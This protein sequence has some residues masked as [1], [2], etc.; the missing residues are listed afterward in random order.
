M[1]NLDANGTMYRHLNN[2]AHQRRS[3]SSSGTYSGSGHRIHER[4]RPA[5]EIRRGKEG[6][7][8]FVDLKAQ[9]RSIK[10]EI[11]E[12]IG[13]VLENSQFILGSEVAAFEEEFARY[14]GGGVG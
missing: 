4:L 11:D 13:K 5:G 14:S 12:A 8:P 6:M 2:A 1:A 9:Y 10:L 3:Q 7:I